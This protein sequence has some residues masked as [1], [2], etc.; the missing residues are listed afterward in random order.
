MILKYVVKVIIPKVIILITYFKVNETS[1]IVRVPNNYP[2]KRVTLSENRLWRKRSLHSVESS[3]WKGI[4]FIANSTWWSSTI[5]VIP[6][7]VRRMP[8]KVRLKD[9]F[10]ASPVHFS[11]LQ[12]VDWTNISATT[13]LS[14]I[15]P[16]RSTEVTWGP[17]GRLPATIPWLWSFV[18]TEGTSTSD[19]SEIWLPLA[20]TWLSKALPVK[21]KTSIPRIFTRATWLVSSSFDRSFL[22][23][24]L[25]LRSDFQSALRR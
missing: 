9:Q 4:K 7:I 2:I 10:E 22:I 1:E 6:R 5:R 20:V 23:Y 24:L 25:F 11:V 21:R 17:R 18:R 12:L 8:S 19:W 3:K 16:K 14:L 15:P 13:N